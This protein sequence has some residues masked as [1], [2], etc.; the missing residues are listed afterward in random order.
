MS[1]RQLTILLL[2]SLGCCV[3]VSAQNN[4][5][6]V[7]DLYDR[8]I[9]VMPVEYILWEI[10]GPR[11]PEPSY[12]YGILYKV[13]ANAFFLIPG[14]DQVIDHTDRLV[15][16]VHPAEM[17]RDHL[18][19][20]T[21]PIDSTLEEILPRSQFLQLKSFVE[22]S[23]S[24]S[25]VYKMGRRYQPLLL[26]QQF[27]CDFCLGFEEGDEPVNYEQYLYQTVDLPLISLTNGWARE[28]WLDIYSQQ[29]QAEMLMETLTNKRR[30]CLNYYDLL[31]A[32]WAQDIETVWQLARE[33]PEFGSNT[34]SLIEARNAEWMEKLP[35]MMERER[36]LIAIHAV[37]L[38]GE[39]GLIHM[40]RKAGYELRPVVR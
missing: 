6:E 32:Y 8:P 35:G 38:P 18:Y 17:D 34:G 29:E 13:P 9:R 2:L 14:L 31:K 37:Q 24:V 15:M 7:V 11:L 28:A 20:G 30:L 39:Y 22:D 36:L 25:S 26:S 1:L 12:L 27:M 5:P 23:L 21:V 3:S 16:E 40:L 33:I 19:R 10:T 4:S